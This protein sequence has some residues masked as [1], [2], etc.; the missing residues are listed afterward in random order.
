MGW[1]FAH[2]GFIWSSASYFLLNT[3][4]IHIMQLLM[5]S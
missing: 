2:F 1:V 5:L 3:I 4:V